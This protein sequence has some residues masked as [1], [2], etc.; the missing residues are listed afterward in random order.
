MNDEL[1]GII[2]QVVQVSPT[3]KVFRIAPDGWELPDFKSGQFCALFLH[4]STPRCA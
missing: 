1:N 2:T 3:M 4:A